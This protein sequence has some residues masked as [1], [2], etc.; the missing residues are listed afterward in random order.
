MRIESVSGEAWASSSPPQPDFSGNR[1]E[2]FMPLTVPP[3]PCCSLLAVV[4]SGKARATTRSTVFQV[5]WFGGKRVR[6][7]WRKRV[8]EP[9]RTEG[10]T[11]KLQPG[12]QSEGMPQA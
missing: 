4:G 7:A 12:Q 8:V 9:S 5:T 3:T 10:R 6:I 11:T 1:F 2:Q